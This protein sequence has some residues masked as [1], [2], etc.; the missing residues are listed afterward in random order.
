MTV[1]VKLSVM[2]FIQY[3]I[4]GAWGVTF[5]TYLSQ[6]LEFDGSQIGLA[7]GATAVDDNPRF[8]PHLRW[9]GRALGCCV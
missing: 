3:F 9:A 2:M 7:V 5:G 6:T 8:V 4:W 1:R